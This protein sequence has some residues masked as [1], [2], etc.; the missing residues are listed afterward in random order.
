[1][2]KTDELFHVGHR[3]RL[4]ERLLDGTLADYEKLELLL[5]Y[6]IPRR[7]VRVLAR[8]LVN[9]FGGIYFVLR[10]PVAELMSVSGVGRNTAILIKLFYELNLISHREYAASGTFFHDAQYLHEYCR[11]ML[12]GRPVEEFHV[13][14]LGNDYKL[15]HDELHARGTIDYAAA[16]PRQIV[17][18]AL[19]LRAVSVILV[20]NHPMSNNSFSHDDIEL[21]TMTENMLNA[22]GIAMVDHLV[23]TSTGI[24]Y[25]FRATPWAKKSSFTKQF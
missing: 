13:F 19:N 23:V 20:H 25:S 24:V 4:K 6:A 18:M 10:A 3:E 5:T 1:M 14:Y 9:H 21:T 7:D 16:Y 15:L 12:V 22:V 17:Q 11:N 2:P 8:S